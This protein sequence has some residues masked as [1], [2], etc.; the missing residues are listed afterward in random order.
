[1]ALVWTRWSKSSFL[2]C[3]TYIR[4]GEPL[5][6]DINSPGRG[7]LG[8]KGVVISWLPHSSAR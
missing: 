2:F 8:A 6:T 3:E 1:M 5:Y 7:I 4:S